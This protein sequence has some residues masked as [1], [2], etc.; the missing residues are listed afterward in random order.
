MSKI[1]IFLCISFSASWLLYN[2]YS[3]NIK[4]S[5]LLYDATASLDKN[6]IVY[7]GD[8]DFKSKTV[9]EVG[10]ESEFGLSKV[11][12]SNHAGTHIDFPSHVIKNGKS[13]S[14]YSL[15]YLIGPGLIINVPIDAK[16]IGIRHVSKF[17]ILKDSI[18]FFKTLNSDFS[19]SGAPRSDY[20]YIEE[21]LAQFLIKKRVRIVGID[22]LSVDHPQNDSLP[23]HK[24]L[25]SNDVLIVENLSLSK[26]KAGKCTIYILP[27]KIESMDGLPSRVL[28]ER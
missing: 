20:V 13:S 26:I 24:A 2:L 3:S 7:P 25:L 15:N 12:L 27:I 1:F 5:R 22:Y 16:S 10:N 21:E 8:P 14:D 19:K 28:I 9:F 11:E 4:R 17:N 18:V 23:I 6:T